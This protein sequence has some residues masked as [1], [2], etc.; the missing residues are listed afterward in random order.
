M[1]ADDATEV[2]VYRLLIVAVENMKATIMMAMHQIVMNISLMNV[3]A[4]LI[5]IDMKEILKAIRIKLY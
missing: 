1:N 3:I 2:V 4:A 5:T